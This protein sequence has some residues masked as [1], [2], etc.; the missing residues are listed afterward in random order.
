MLAIA[1]TEN[2]FNSDTDA[3]SGYDIII[4]QANDNYR[5]EGYYILVKSVEL[6]VKMLDNGWRMGLAMLFYSA[7]TFENICCALQKLFNEDMP[8]WRDA[9]SVVEHLFV[10]N[11]ERQAQDILDA[12]NF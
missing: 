5:Q 10:S 2:I 12:L 9:R 8:A 11:A 1:Q 7:D 4:A 6:A 3:L